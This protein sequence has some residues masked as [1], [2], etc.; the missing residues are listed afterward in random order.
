MMEVMG[1]LIVDAKKPAIPTSAK[2]AGWMLIDSGSTWSKKSP[3]AAPK[4]PPHTNA[5]AKS[6]P[7]PPDP[8]VKEVASAL[9]K[10]NVRN[11]TIAIGAKFSNSCPNPHL[12]LASMIE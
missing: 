7:D 9:T 4:A 8:T 5:G 1:I 11:P 3:T 2:A 6:P 10:K 12:R